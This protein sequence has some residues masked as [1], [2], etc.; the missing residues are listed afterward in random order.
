MKGRFVTT[1][2]ADV[3][4][5]SSQELLFRYLSNL[6]ENDGLMAWMFLV[7]LYKQRIEWPTFDLLKMAT[8]VSD[9]LTHIMVWLLSLLPVTRGRCVCFLV[10]PC[11]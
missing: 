1:R 4:P 3:R 11:V 7:L 10:R 5:T 2:T 6:G 8:M 9:W